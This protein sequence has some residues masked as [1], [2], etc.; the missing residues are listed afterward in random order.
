MI[1]FM[2]QGEQNAAGDWMDTFHFPDDLIGKHVHMVGIKGTGMTAL[3]ELLAGKL[4][5][6][7]GSDTG[8]KFYTDE[9]LASLQVKV[10]EKFSK[11]NIADD[12]VMVIYSAA[13][14][15]DTNPDLE[16]ANRRGI[17][18]ITYP[19]ALGLLSRRSA[20]AAISGVHG[21]TTTTAMAGTIVKHLKL[22]ATTIAGSQVFSFGNRSTYS[23]GEKYLI[24]ET[25]EYKR[26]FLR[27]WP[28][29][30]VM[31]AIELDHPDYFKDLADV[32][33]A[34]TEFGCSLP[35]EGTLIYCSDDI[36]AREV[37]HR[38]A[39]LRPD[40]VMVPYGMSAPGDFQLKGIC[41]GKE[42]IRFVLKGFPDDFILRV[43]GIHSVYDATGAIALAT[44]LLRKEKALITQA[45][46]E[47]MRRG[48][49]EFSGS[50]RRTEILGEAAGILFMDDYAHHPTAVLSTLKGI[51]EFYPERRLVVDF[52]SHTYSRTKALL[53]SFGKC[54]SP[55]H[56]LVLH[57][58][59]ASAREKGAGEISGKELFDEV[60]KHHKN[61]FYYEEVSDAFAFLETYLAPGDIFLT[62][63]AGDN[64]K[65]G[66]RIYES[67][68]NK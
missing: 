50:K 16:E 24:A 57:R 36:G 2:N 39:A 31:T 38:V 66:K 33:A 46:M 28:S 67:M 41:S 12:T 27:F 20:S 35:Q 13:Y 45:D 52:M 42:C 55:A 47:N 18:C 11:D 14:G 29:Y 30:I 58:I 21:K 63:G 5:S 17:R 56:T 8:E 61:V 32:Y 19:E 10:T 59:Y 43:P 7:T 9:I 1:S 23:T 40:I 34:F 65:I 26:N 51:R 62:M 15:P 4:V 64:W 22:A 53:E 48:L 37:A 3:A 49:E 25:C 6:V 44:T 54:F 68:K 60:A